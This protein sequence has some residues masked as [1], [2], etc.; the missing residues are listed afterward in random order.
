MIEETKNIKLKV[1]RTNYNKEESPHYDEFDVSVK[2]WTTVL[3]ALLD[4]KSYSDSSLGIR[5]F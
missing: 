5:Y 1:Y 4:A 3:D 2:R